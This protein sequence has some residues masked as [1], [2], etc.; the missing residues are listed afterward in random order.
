MLSTL[1][2]AITLAFGPISVCSDLGPAATDETL[3][4]LY[5]AGQ[6]FEDFMGAAVRRKALWDGNYARSVE[7]DQALVERA[8]AVGGTWRFLAVAMDSC[9]D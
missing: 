7:I 6:T 1:A 2:M 5:Q 8:R 9:S 3:Q 4:E